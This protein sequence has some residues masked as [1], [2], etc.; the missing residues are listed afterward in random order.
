MTAQEK[1]YKRMSETPVAKL[2]VMLG[3]P[4][5]ISM[6]ITNI[7]NLVDTYFV[8]GLGESA[9]GATGIL[10]TLQAIIQ[11]IAF[12]LGHGSGTFVAKALADKNNKEATTYI[13][14]AFYIGL[15]LGLILSIFG[16]IF[17]KPFMLLLG[18]TDTILPYAI[19]YGLWVLIS[20]PFL[21]ASMVL[22]NNLRYEGKAFFSMIGLCSG[23]LL[24][25]L[26][27][28]I[29]IIEY[30]LGVFGA[31]M[32]TAI[33]Q[34]ISFIILLYLYIKYAQ[35]KIDI[36]SISKDKF[37][38]LD[39][40][41]V[42]LP[43]LI[44]Q[45][46]T[47]ISGGILNNLAKAYGDACIAAMTIVNR[48][49][50]FV[51]CVGLGIGQGFQPVAS[52]NYQTKD[53]T[54]VKKGLIFTTVF[55]TILIST[56]AALGFVYAKDIIYLF[57]KSD[58]VIEIGTFALRAAS[59]GAVFLPI[60]VSANMLY[61]SIRKSAIASFLSL[62]RSGLALIPTLIILTNLYNIVGIQLSQP[63]SDVISSLISLPFFILFLVKTPN[64][65]KND[66][67]LVNLD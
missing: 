56:I 67:E 26:G 62:L 53:Y 12:M 1:H 33:S 51:L 46:L 28:Y 43:S 16:L 24:N 32:S 2:I 63:I 57:Q 59:V 40:F 11:A 22:N 6:L 4:T 13:S 48:Y 17:I 34:I 31:G 47:S 20:A 66:Y 18:S 5:T 41:K 37:L 64:T 8:G 45:G 54:R 65:Q 25:I 39:I 30:N 42:G 14:T 27:D 55:G 21:I 9:Q 15:G 52:F 3:I 58:R 60:S 36:K 61:Q 49:S 7:Y 19:D 38:Y 50:S 23:A 10:F 29:F 44:R 35:S